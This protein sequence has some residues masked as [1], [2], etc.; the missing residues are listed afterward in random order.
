M[1]A[2]S[3]VAVAGPRV[4]ALALAGPVPGHGG[5]LRPEPEREHVPAAGGGRQRG[6]SERSAPVAATGG[7]LG[8]PGPATTSGRL[9]LTTHKHH[10]GPVNVT[11][12]L[13][14]QPAT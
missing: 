8:P 14:L 7:G 3:L 5:L 12:P 11:A 1:R 4:G 2:G 13:E 10:D 9:P 6:L